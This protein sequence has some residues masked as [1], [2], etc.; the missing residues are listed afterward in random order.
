MIKSRPKTDLKSQRYIVWQG[1]DYRPALSEMLPTRLLRVLRK[2]Q[3]VLE[4]GCNKGQ[5]AVFLAQH[6]LQV[7]GI[8]INPHALREATALADGL[9][10]ERGVHFEVGDFL[11]R[12]WRSRFDAVVMIRFLTCLPLVEDWRTALARARAALKPGAIIYVR[13]FLF[14][15]ANPTYRQRY[16][17]GQSNGWRTGNFLVEQAGQ[18]SFVA[19]HHTD[20]DIDEIERPYEIVGWRTEW[21]RSLHGNRCRM[22]EF[23]GKK[24]AQDATVDSGQRQVARASDGRRPALRGAVSRSF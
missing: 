18:A 2:G 22:F 7:H 12:S 15:P 8:D 21:S 19:H 24:G 10:V 16:N 3:L 5:V 1:I 17:L 4:T 6:G 23:I 20:A 13:D 14:D 11:T 9:G